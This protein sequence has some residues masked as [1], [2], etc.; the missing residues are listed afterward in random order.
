MFVSINIAKD[1]TKVRARRKFRL[2]VNISGNCALQFVAH[3]FFTISCTVYR[4]TAVTALFALLQIN[5]KIVL[6]VVLSDC[7]TCPLSVIERVGVFEDNMRRHLRE[8]KR[9]R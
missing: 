9:I 6:R 3:N 4:Y 1:K 5:K 8:T 2:T 7:K